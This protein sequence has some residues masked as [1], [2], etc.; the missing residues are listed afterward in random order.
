MSRYTLLAVGLTAFCLGMLPSP[1]RAQWGHHGWGHDQTTIQVYTHEEVQPTVRVITRT[2]DEQDDVRIYQQWYNT[3]ARDYNDIDPVSGERL[4]NLIHMISDVTPDYLMVT[5]SLGAHQ[6]V[7]L[8][9]HTTLLFQPCEAFR[10]RM[11]DRMRAYPDPGPLAASRLVPGDLVV[12]EGVLKASGMFGAS[13]IRVVGH[14]W[15][16]DTDDY[17]TLPLDY[18]MRGWG[19]VSDLDI[20]RQRVEVQCQ[21]GLRSLVLAPN[22]DVVVNGRRDTLNG[23]RRNDHVIFYYRRD[24]ITPIEVYRIVLVGEGQEYPPTAGAS[25]ADPVATIVETTTLVEGEVEYITTGVT[26]Y[27]LHIRDHGNVFDIRVGK[28][29]FVLG[30]HGEHIPLFQLRDKAHLRIHSY[31]V[32][33]AM[34]A[35]RL[36]L[37]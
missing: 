20:D 19:T 13:K 18:G 29:A 17:G 2:V 1:S 8:T 23:L 30:H 12:L 28:S 34:F 14:A 9:N 22:A 24:G 16:W 33:E 10:R 11:G 32:G 27:K 37:P 26:F 6:T 5:N 3:Q 31:K 4:G 36:E 15:G 21:A 7:M 25:W 35:G